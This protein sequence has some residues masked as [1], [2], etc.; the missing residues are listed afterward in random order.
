MVFKRPGS[1][2]VFVAPNGT[3]RPYAR[4][5][6][7]LFGKGIKEKRVYAYRPSHP[8]TAHARASSC[9]AVALFPACSVLM[10]T[11]CCPSASVSSYAHRKISV[12]K[13][14]LQGG[15]CPRRLSR[16]PGSSSSKHMHQHGSRTGQ[17]HRP[18]RRLSR[19]KNSFLLMHMCNAM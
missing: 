8:P 9:S 7:R 5:Q 14:I 3:G 13:D 4:R 11:P 18:E 19:H 17:A 15:R 6:P 2:S 16:Q 1:L 10:I 12:H